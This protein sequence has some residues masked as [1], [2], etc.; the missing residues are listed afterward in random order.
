VTSGSPTRMAA[1][2]ESAW[3]ARYLER[4]LSGEELAWFEA[5]LLDKP[6]LLAMVEADN[7]LKDAVA[8]E[9][10]GEHSGAQQTSSRV[11]VDPSKHY[12]TNRGLAAAAAVF[13][14]GLGI[15]WSISLH[16]TE[17]FPA[18]IPD[19]TRI[20]YDTMRGTE[21]VQLVERPR[22]HTPYVLVEVALPVTARAISLQIGDREPEALTLSPDGFISFLVLRSI[23]NANP[24]IAIRYE[25]GG[26]IVERSIGLKQS[27]ETK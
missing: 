6:E 4:Q 11:S 24:A 15:G 27:M 19:P 26:K 18:S 21:G 25:I 12:I 8:F 16:R 23:A 7:S 1:W 3:L 5:Y 22:S 14:V 13:V 17:A 2:L 9:A 20:V 10:A